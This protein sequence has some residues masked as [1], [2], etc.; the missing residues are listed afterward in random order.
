MSED[1]F[2][3]ALCIVIFVLFIKFFTQIVSLALLVFICFF[4]VSIVADH[5]EFS[6]KFNN[7]L[8]N[9]K[10]N[11]DIEGP[12]NSFSKAFKYLITGKEEYTTK[13]KINNTE[14]GKFK[15]KI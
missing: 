10:I 3:C 2:I 14:I 12:Q 15:L 4:L 7:N 9:A 6:K 8:I 5:G 13:I 1:I 11:V